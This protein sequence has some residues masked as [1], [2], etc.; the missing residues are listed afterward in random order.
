MNKKTRD[1]LA[2][3]IFALL[4]LYCIIGAVKVIASMSEMSSD[5]VMLQL[6]AKAACLFPLVVSIVLILKNKPEKIA[7]IRF[8]AI[9]TAGTYIPFAPGIRAE[10]LPVGSP[11]VTFA[12]ATIA[13]FC[14]VLFYLIP[15][16]KD[17]MASVFGPS[18]DDADDKNNEEE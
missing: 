18:G 6:I 3:V 2:I 8:V 7:K 14:A 17:S 13:L 1:T 16:N 9:F 5:S 15:S 12:V 10:A 11:A 4:A